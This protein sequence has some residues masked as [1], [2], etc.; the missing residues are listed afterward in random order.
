MKLL[1]SCDEYC[2]SANGI[3]YFRDAGYTLLKRYLLVFEQI[4]VAVRTRYVQESELGIYNIPIIDACIEI[5]PLPFFQGPKQY[6]NVFVETQK[7]LR[8]IAE[9]CQA[10]I[11]RMPSSIAYTILNPVQRKR[12]PYGVEVVANPKDL[13][14]RGGFIKRIF[15]KMLHKNL[16][17][18]CMEAD[19]ISYVTQYILQRIYPDY[20]DGHYETFYSSVDLPKN[21]Y[22]KP[23]EEIHTP[24]VLCHVAHNIT[25]RGK[26]QDVLINVASK[27]IKKGYNIQVKMAGM[28]DAIGYFRSLAGS[29]DIDGQV[30]FVGYLNKEN[31]RSFFESSDLMVFPTLSEGLPRV[32]IE[33]MSVGLPCVSTPVGGIPELLE[34]ECLLK[35]DD[36]SGFVSI[37]ERFITDKEFYKKQSRINYTKSLEYSSDVLTKRRIDMYNAL[38]LMAESKTI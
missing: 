26:G 4:R 20:K 22:G 12:I 8:N 32:L 10:C 6:L 34:D 23:R 27:L 36:V 19:A 28:G 37:V 21:Q 35:P 13:S 9:E 14:L 11:V 3:F 24:F 16:Q 17:K 1:F 29:L 25:K 33:A 38:K 5:Y 2:Y 7:K 30:E 15:W 31:L 18:V